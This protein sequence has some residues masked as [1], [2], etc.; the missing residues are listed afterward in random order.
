M[1]TS[2]L[3]CGPV[4]S[5]VALSATGMVDPREQGI[6]TSQVMTVFAVFSFSE[7]SRACHI[8]GMSDGFKMP[9]IYARFVTAAMIQFKSLWNWTRKMFVKEPVSQSGSVHGL[10]EFSVWGM[11]ENRPLPYPA[12]IDVNDIV[13]QWIGRY[14]Y[15]S[16][17]RPRTSPALIMLAAHAPSEGFVPVR[18]VTANR[19]TGHVPYDTK[20][21]GVKS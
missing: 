17:C 6:W 19:T 18:T 5:F 15:G 4:V 2:T 7:P 16:G 10:T 12:T 8:L 21:R 1:S 9:W 11:L 20:V 13:R 14:R 3:R